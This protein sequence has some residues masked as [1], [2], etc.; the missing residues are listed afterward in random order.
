MPSSEDKG[1]ARRTI[2]V[3][4]DSPLVLRGVDRTL[5]RAGFVVET[6]LGGRDCLALVE[7]SEPRLVLL[8]L[9]MPEVDGWTVLEELA[10]RPAPPAVIVCS[11]SAEREE[12]RRYPFVV[13]VLEKPLMPAALL[14]AVRAAPVMGAPE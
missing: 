9:H 8:D 7:R 3:V 14:D 1:A 5:S 10:A 11:S 6:C 4:D 13:D 2:L 12:A